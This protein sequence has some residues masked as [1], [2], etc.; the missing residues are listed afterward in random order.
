MA[1]TKPLKPAPDAPI[2]ATADG[3]TIT[4]ADLIATL[5]EAKCPF[6]LHHF[7]EA[8]DPE[9]RWGAKVNETKATSADPVSA[10]LEALAG[11]LAEEEQ[12]AKKAQE[13]ADMCIARVTKLRAAL[14]HLEVHRPTDDGERC[15][16]GKVHSSADGPPEVVRRM[17]EALG[18]GLVDVKL[19]R[20]D[21][22]AAKPKQKS[23]G[24]KEN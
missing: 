22:G 13:L 6:S 20:V 12:S 2:V 9:E 17:L 16:C 15:I 19:S 21:V 10:M 14:P 4:L 11:G 3:S 8:E 1:N 18:G 23:K 7:A 5:I 24:K